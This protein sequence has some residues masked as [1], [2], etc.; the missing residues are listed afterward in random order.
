MLGVL[1]L[2]LTEMAGQLTVIVTGPAVSLAGFASARALTVAVL[3][4]EPQAVTVVTALRMTVFDAPAASVPKLQVS[5][6]VLRRS[7]SSE[8]TRRRRSRSPSR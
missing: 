4:T 5:V 6:V 3:S 7:A 8:S 1:V 2:L